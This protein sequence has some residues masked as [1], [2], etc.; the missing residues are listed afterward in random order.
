MK[1]SLSLAALFGVVALL[2]A[3][4]W[5]SKSSTSENDAAAGPRAAAPPVRESPAAPTATDT[6]AAASAAARTELAGA[7]E[8]A[9]SSAPGT[10]A[11]VR[12]QRSV[13]VVDG[14]TRTPLANVEVLYEEFATDGGAPSHAALD[15]K[16]LDA[17]LDATHSSVRTDAAGG[18]VLDTRLGRECVVVA[19]APGVLG[20][21]R[22]ERDEQG[23]RQLELWPDAPLE[24]LVLGPQGAPVAALQVALS[25]RSFNAFSAQHFERTDDAGRARF[26]HIGLFLAQREGTWCVEPA[27]LFDEGARVMLDRAAPPRDVVVLH[28]PAFG[29]VELRAWD[30]NGAPLASGMA[31]L[32]PIEPGAELGVQPS[33]LHRRLEMT[34]AINNGVARFEPVRVGGELELAVAGEGDSSQTQRIR[35]PTS[36]GEVV[37]AEHRD[38]RSALVLRA[39]LVDEQGAV[40]AE[41]DV[42]CRYTAKRPIDPDM[43]ESEQKSD[44]Q[45]Y[46]RF[47]LGSDR[48]QGEQ[49]TLEF[50]VEDPN[51]N[52]RS[53]KIELAAAY[54]PGEHDLGD[55]RLALPPVVA[56]GRVVDAQGAAVAGAEVF[57]SYMQASPRGGGQGSA[58][59]RSRAD[60]SFEVRAD[61]SCDEVTLNASL[62]LAL[63]PRVR[64]P[65][66][67]QGVELVLQA[68]GWID[69]RLLLDPAVASTRPRVH[70]RRV[71]QGDSE[72]ERARSR[73]TN[74]TQVQLD[75]TF[76]LEPL[77]PGRYDLDILG[78]HQFDPLLS[79]SGFEVP[80][81]AGCADARLPG[82]DLRGK[83]T[84][85]RLELVPPDPSDAVL[86]TLDVQP[87]ADGVS[88]FK[89]WLH[90]NQADIVIQ[91]PA[92]RVAVNVS[93]F[94][95]EV[96]ERVSSDTR[97]Q[98]RRGPRVR[99]KAPADAQIPA[100]PMF[101]KAS[102][103]PVG[104]TG[105]GY[106]HYQAAVFDLN[107]ELVLHAPGAGDFLVSWS[108]E[109]RTDSSVSTTSVDVPDEQRITVLESDVEQI[110]EIRWPAE[111][112]AQALKR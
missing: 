61:W 36:Q 96:L 86:G 79:L 17:W 95:V 29:A 51:S 46:V 80:S 82:I 75:G 15:N 77:E 58:R 90:D 65:R 112:L 101:V 62:S 5:F 20:R 87:L 70:A 63:A 72:D 107:R 81:G 73:P 76:R 1:R 4:L 33:F 108:V 110:F 104:S 57:A 50:K 94:R 111:A 56:A 68:S 14:P 74:R 39:R 105:A 18:A 48:A 97:V 45:G 3:A 21:A 24:V 59:A 31:Q 11:A 22:F 30:A 7:A 42:K 32:V 40:L 98:L 34:S 43:Q 69:G 53:A 13:L 84:A 25:V 66:G 60:G 85:F 41:R 55:V 2:A 99:L 44:V 92:A 100:A 28:T 38:P 71:D 47:P 23:L 78:D 103:S 106:D 27:G 64:V 16:R 91:A 109:E 89:M 49:R 12:A 19:R 37:T 10:V 35:A 52:V 26:E 93:G 54:A 67:A 8:T 102:L 6:P 83:L 9:P 88:A